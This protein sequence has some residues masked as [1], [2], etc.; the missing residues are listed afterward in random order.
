MIGKESSCLGKIMGNVILRGCQTPILMN[1]MLY[2][3]VLFGVY[4]ESQTSNYLYFLLRFRLSIAPQIFSPTV[5]KK[6]DQS[7]ALFHNH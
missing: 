4:L 3:I 1:M 2:T 6:W 7:I 5:L